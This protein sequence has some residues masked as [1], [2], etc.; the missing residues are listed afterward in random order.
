MGSQRALRPGRPALLLAAVLLVALGQ[1]CAAT[2]PEKDLEDREE[3]AN[4][5]LTGTVDEIIN[6]DPVHNT[7]SCKVSDFVC[8]L[9]Y[10]F[11]GFFSFYSPPSPSHF[12]ERSSI[13]SALP[14]RGGQIHLLFLHQI[15][16][17]NQHSRAFTYE[18]KVILTFHS[19]S[20][21]LETEM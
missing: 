5:V 6:M 3:E 4:V 10:A 17:G 11:V 14:E 7:Y 19:F 9:V 12:W 2:C 13:R 21:P 20:S 1:R 8:L 16:V 18:G 15:K